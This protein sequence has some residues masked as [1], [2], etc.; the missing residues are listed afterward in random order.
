MKMKKITAATA[1]VALLLVTGCA[2]N[3][4]TIGTGPA[5]HDVKIERQWYVLFGLVPINNVDS[6]VMAGDA[7]NYQIMTQQSFVDVVIS[8][9]TSWVSVNCR[10]V[11]VTK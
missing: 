2:T 7:Q 10:S 5:G 3:I 11:T 1:L 6:K 9:F 8:A 4:H